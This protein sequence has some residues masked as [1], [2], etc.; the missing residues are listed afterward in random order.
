MSGIKVFRFVKLAW[1]LVTGK[2]YSLRVEKIFARFTSC[3]GSGNRMLSYAEEDLIVDLR[4][5][6]R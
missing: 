6:A 2:K 4:R 5:R 3:L 1:S